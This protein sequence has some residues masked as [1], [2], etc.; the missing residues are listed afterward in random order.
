MDEPPKLKVPDETLPVEKTP[1][2]AVAV[3]LTDVVGG[4]FNIVNGF[5]PVAIIYLFLRTKIRTIAPAPISA[6]FVNVALSI[7]KIVWDGGVTAT[8]C[9]LAC[10]LAI[11]LSVI[12]EYIWTPLSSNFDKLPTASL[13]KPPLDCCGGLFGLTKTS[14]AISSPFQFGIFGLII[15][16]V[17]PENFL[18]IDI[19]VTRRG[20]CPINDL[21]KILDALHR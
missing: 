8:A 16:H 9:A 15:D 14:P 19:E 18:G 12:A 17:K 21:A 6:Y 10:F 11:D 13:Q 1:P 5:P 20:T 4:E 7:P 3:G 2:D